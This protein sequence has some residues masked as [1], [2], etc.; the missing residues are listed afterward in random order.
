MGFLRRPGPRLAGLCA[1]LLSWVALAQPADLSA[2]A[3]HPHL[4]ETTRRSPGFFCPRLSDAPEEAYCCRSPAAG[5]ACC[6]RAEFEALYRVNLS[7]L[8][9]PPIFRGTGPLLALGLYCLLLAALMAADLAHFCRG[10]GRSRGR[11][12]GR[13]RGRERARAERRGRSSQAG[14]GRR[15]P[16][17]RSSAA[18]PLRVPVGTT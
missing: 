16:P 3:H 4:C 17:S 15:G 7:A 6:T 2:L 10:R 8:P 1:G 5:D 14:C 12:R 11:G 13:G 18:R 9:P